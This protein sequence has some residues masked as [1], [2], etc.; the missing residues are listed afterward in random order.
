M[1]QGHECVVFAALAL[2]ALLAA[3]RA[4][5]AGSRDGALWRDRRTSEHRWQ[6]EGGRE[7]RDAAHRAVVQ[8]PRSP[9]AGSRR[10]GARRPRRLLPSVTVSPSVGPA[11]CPHGPPRRGPPQAEGHGR[12]RQAGRH[13]LGVWGAG[14]WPIWYLLPYIG[15]W[16]S[17]GPARSR[18]LRRWRVGLR[19]ACSA[20][21]PC[22]IEGLTMHAIWD[23]LSSKTRRALEPKLGQ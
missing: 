5:V 15:L 19:G 6:R 9:H 10:W 1:I 14:C 3:R 16:R 7:Q 22:S 12:R 8:Q 18:G 11:A 23:K 2:R 13:R 17:A 20:G 21:M 4:H